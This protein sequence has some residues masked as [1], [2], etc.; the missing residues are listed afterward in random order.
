MLGNCVGAL[1]LLWPWA[2]QGLEDFAGTFLFLRGKCQGILE[3]F[4]C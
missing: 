4:F 2:D 1:P 3:F